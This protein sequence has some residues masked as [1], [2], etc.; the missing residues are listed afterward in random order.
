MF[1]IEGRALVKPDAHRLQ[2]SPPSRPQ[3]R[4]KIEKQAQKSKLAS[5]SFGQ[6]ACETFPLVLF[7]CFFGFRED[8]L[9]EGV[10]GSLWLCF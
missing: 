6:A 1:V 9:F 3:N 2:S 7:F 8:G 10:M 5:R 4:T